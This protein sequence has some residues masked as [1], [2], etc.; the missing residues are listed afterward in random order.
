MDM[1]NPRNALIDNSTLS[2]VERLLGVSKVVNLS[3]IDHDI[4][5]YEKLVSSILLYDDI[6]MFDDYKKHYSDRRKDVFKYISVID[7][8]D[9]DHNLLKERS[10]EYAQSQLFE[11]SGSVPV[12]KTLKFFEQLFLKPQLRWNIFVSSEYLTLSYLVS[13]KSEE[14]YVNTFAASLGNEYTDSQR[15]VNGESSGALIRRDEQE[16]VDVEEFIERIR[17]K[18]PNYSGLGSKDTL[19]KLVFA[20]GWLAER[21]FFYEAVG[22]ASN[23]N[24]IV[25]PLRDAFA[26]A[27]TG[28]EPIQWDENFVNIASKSAVSLVKEINNAVDSTAIVFTLP[29]FTAWIMARAQNP[30]EGLDMALQLKSEKEFR[31]ARDLLSN[32]SV[33]PLKEKRAEIVKVNKAL[34]AVLDEIRKKYVY[35]G[36]SGSFLSFSVGLSGP[37]LDFDIIPQSL[38]RI[39][40]FG[41]NPVSRMYRSMVADIQNVERLGALHDKMTIEVR[42]GKSA[43]YGGA[44]TTPFFMKNKTNE[45]GGPIG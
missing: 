18:N 19:M 3:N 6:K 25:S 2:G 24:P 35:S 31:E 40:K 38:K 4:C 1:L 14:N 16:A 36:N 27:S 13:E 29:F 20:Y 5:C 9:I 12:G 7:K 23:C 32:L 10:A 34:Q 22:R 33:L 26:L 17:S 43:V 15:T 11:L 42:K 30:S 8:T 37:S 39:L 45:Y 21:S 28:L 44:P 41:A